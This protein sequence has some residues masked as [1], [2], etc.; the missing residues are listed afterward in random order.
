MSLGAPIGQYRVITSGL[1]AQEWIIIEGLQKMMPG[2][3]VNPERIS[4]TPSKAE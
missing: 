2:V 1:T 3:Q 4:L